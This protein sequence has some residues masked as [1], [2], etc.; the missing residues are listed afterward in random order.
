[1]WG[2]K[3]LGGAGLAE[4]Q[5]RAGHHAMRQLS[6]LAQ[7]SL[8]LPMKPPVPLLWYPINSGFHY[9][10]NSE[11]YKSV[12][13]G[14]AVMTQSALKS[15]TSHER[16]VG[17]QISISASEET[18]IQSTAPYKDQINWNLT[19]MAGN[20]YLVSSLSFSLLENVSQ[21]LPFC[22][23]LWCECTP[24]RLMN[25]IKNHVD[26]KGYVKAC[27]SHSAFSLSSFSVIL[28][29]KI[30]FC[31]GLCFAGSKAKMRVLKLISRCVTFNKKEKNYHRTACSN[32]QI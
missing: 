15:P 13:E 25:S 2:E 31:L 8:L 30:K 3:L 5:V 14:R 17:D 32:I 1:M 6:K 10:V 11:I 26:F 27:H 12:H 19:T 23:H 24:F 4:S 29:P 7:V 22:F 16:Y 20:T 21:T 18:N 28:L 9:S